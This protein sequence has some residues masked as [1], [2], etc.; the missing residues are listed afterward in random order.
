MTAIHLVTT[1]GPED[2]RGHI[3]RA[4]AMAEAL[5]G[6]GATVSL[7]V[8]RGAPSPTQANRLEVLGVRMDP[9]DDDDAIAL[10]DLPD[11][12]ETGDRWPPERLAVFDDRE[13]FRG[14]VALLIQPSLAT[15]GGPADAGRI[16]AGY[17]YA[18]VRSAIRRLAAEHP[19][20]TT[21]AA[22]VVCFGGSDPAD[23]SARLAP[24]IAGASR[25]STLTVVGPDYRGRLVEIGLDPDTPGPVLRDPIDLDRR[26]A[27]AS[28]VVSGAGTM[29]FE[30]GLLGRPAILLAV[31]DDQ[32]PV[33]PAFAATG[34]A[35]YLGDGRTIDPA[36]VA[37]EVA[38]LVAD[39]PARAAMASRGPTVVDG[40]GADRIADALL[41]LASRPGRSAAR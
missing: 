12:N 19:A 34:A 15:W 41:Q 14:A 8:L 5:L 18:P 6:S 2:G 30:L 10:L 38:T 7:E 20:E 40:R 26:M 25:W 23:V 27:T 11:P 4:V 31:A 22:V 1:A 33:G 9:P 32:L 39:G 16:L 28:L 36:A 3:S 21:P 37:A 35:R 24:A 29:K 17:D 13:S